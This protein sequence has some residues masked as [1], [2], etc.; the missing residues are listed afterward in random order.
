[1]P[2]QR[3]DKAPVDHVGG[4]QTDGPWPSEVEEIARGEAYNRPVELADGSTQEATVTV[5]EIQQLIRDD[6]TETDG[7]VVVQ[8]YDDPTIGGDA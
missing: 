2:V 4:P 1:M 8:Q 7:Y 6:G 5:S 3:S